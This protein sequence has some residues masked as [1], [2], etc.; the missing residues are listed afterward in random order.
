MGTIQKPLPVKLFLAVMYHDE[1]DKDRALKVFIEGFGNFDS[2]HGPL[3][4]NAYTSYYDKEMGRGLKK[5][6]FTFEK[7]VDRNRLPDIK[8]FTNLIEHDLRVKKSRI[9][10]LD[11][12]YLT[13][14]KLVLASTKDFFHRIYLDK[15]IYAEITLHF[16]QGKFK[17]FSW[18]YPDYKDRGVHI[19][20]A[21]SRGILIKELNKREKQ[22][23][24]EE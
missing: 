7:L 16:R 13:S 6:F 5:Y 11:P 3:D 24:G 4:V 23:P 17:Y 18:T 14:E 15:G 10:N 8:I 2:H 9:V 20:L 21:E 1:K 12:G 19:F 22:N